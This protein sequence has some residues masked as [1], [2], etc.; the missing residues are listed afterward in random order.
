MKILFYTNIPSPY[1]VDFF[2]ELGK[3]CEL[4]VL[5]ETGNSKER[6]EAWKD[7]K[8]INFR[9]IIL[10][11]IRTG[12]DSSFCPEIVTYLKKNQY[13]HIVV[14]Q[15]ASFTAIW[16]VLY[17]YIKGIPYCYEGDGGFAGSRKGLKA[18][19]KRFIIGNASY[20][21]STS[22][23][24]DEYCEAY[25]AK[26]DKIYRYSFT[27]V[28]EKDLLE[29]PLTK[30]EKLQI[31]NVLNMK[32]DYILLSVGQFI[33]RKGFDLLLEM[34]RFLPPTIGIYIVGGKPTAEY[35]ELKEK[36]NLQ[37]VHFVDFMEKE[38][39][40]KY[41]QAAD[42]FV[43]PT[44]EDI[45]GLVVNEAMANGLPVVSTDRCVAALEM[46]ETGKNGYIVPINDVSEMKKAVE[47]ILDSVQIWKDMSEDAL[48]T[49][50]QNYTIEKMVQD[51]IKI[52]EKEFRVK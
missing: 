37:Q 47:S 33:Y 12:T 9:G 41:Y 18:G 50:R 49:M 7:Y 5:F 20:C 35:L 6:N 11:G 23:V 15:V 52:F 19:I 1:R 3:Y 42:V 43:F 16:A 39:L 44:R 36:W 10:K 22:K 31:R 51:H 13:D 21:L 25:G 14:T 26:K 28:K 17:M 8:F 4:T 38:Q 34:S 24:F 40:K 32:E 27:S 46:I 2:N 30:E 29:R 45:W 48:E